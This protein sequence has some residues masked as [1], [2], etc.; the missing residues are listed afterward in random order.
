MKIIFL[1]VIM[2][3]LL[4]CTPSDSNQN[5]NGQANIN[6]KTMTYPVK[7]ISV[8]I[9]RPAA[10]VYQFAANPENF[11]KWVAFVQSLTRQGD[12]WVGETTLGT[13]RIKFTPQNDFGIIDHLVTLPTGEAVENHMRVITNNK[14]CEFIFTLFRLPGR[15]DEEFKEDANAVTKDLQKLKEIME[16]K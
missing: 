14:G 2:P 8:S 12:S 6:D 9:N 16:R 15:T 7:H 13:I 5:S 3:L 10:D 1:T 4:A 11:P